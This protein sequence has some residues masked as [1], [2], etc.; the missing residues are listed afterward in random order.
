M[1]LDPLGALDPTARGRAVTALDGL[2]P[3][4][5]ILC[6][7]ST[8][9]FARIATQAIALRAPSQTAASSTVAPAPRLAEAA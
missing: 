3:G 1:L 9:T 4:T 8:G 2:G 6:H 7:D 5:T